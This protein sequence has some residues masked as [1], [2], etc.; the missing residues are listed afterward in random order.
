ME[1]RTGLLRAPALRPTGHHLRDVRIGYPANPS[2]RDRVLAPVRTGMCPRAPSL[3]QSAIHLG[4][5]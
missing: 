1:E 2:T 5:L 4:R 3:A